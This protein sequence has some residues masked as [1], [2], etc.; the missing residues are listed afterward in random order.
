MEI[1]KDIGDYEGLYQVSNMG[2]VKSLARTIIKRR[3]LLGDYTA[4]VAERILK[5]SPNNKGYPVVN[6][7]KNGKV[8]MRTVHTLVAEAFI[9]PPQPGEE[10]RHGDGVRSNPA[11]YNL[12]YGTR[13]QNVEDA[14]AHGTFGGVNTGNAQLNAEQVREIRSQ[15]STH[16]QIL[17]DFYGVKVDRIR[18]VWARRT[19]ASVI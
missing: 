13:K 1:W 19:Y 16:A 14:I 4:P 10:V 15:R 17:A 8:I 18:A 7:S 3:K 6:L 9:G 11:L 12:C 5:P 2:R